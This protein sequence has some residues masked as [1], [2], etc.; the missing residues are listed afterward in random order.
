MTAFVWTKMGVESG[1]QLSQIVL[2]KDKERRSGNGIFW[3]GTGSSLGTAVRE[4][5]REQGGRLPVLFSKM[6]THAKSS[7][8]SPEIVWKWTKW[9]DEKGRSQ[10][11][12]AHVN[13]ISRGADSKRKHYALAC[14]SNKPLTLETN[15]KF[16]PT[17]YRT[18]AGKIPGSSQ[19]TALLIGS[20]RGYPTG[21]MK[22][23]FE[24]RWLNLGPLSF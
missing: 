11:I 20:P 21:P 9:E 6:R 17:N 12:P 18:P 23:H 8:V 10:L 4:R 1:E 13:V 16:D 15:E 5:A 14:Y 7:D 19:V 2:R 24:R 3:W 22:F